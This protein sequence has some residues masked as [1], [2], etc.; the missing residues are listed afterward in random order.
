VNRLPWVFFA[1]CVAVMEGAEAN[2]YLQLG[3]SSAVTSVTL[4]PEVPIGSE[5]CL[6]APVLHPAR[7]AR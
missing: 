2:L 7:S 3:H 6:G 5:R 4:S 1:L